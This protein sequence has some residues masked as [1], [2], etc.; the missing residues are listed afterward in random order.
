MP[1]CE[2]ITSPGDMS[3]SICSTTSG[4]PPYSCDEEYSLA[5]RSTRVPESVVCGD[6]EVELS[7]DGVS[8]VLD[9]GD[10]KADGSL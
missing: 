8:H 7:H 2:Q 4:A 3:A 5:T 6:Q 10:A 1:R 9:G